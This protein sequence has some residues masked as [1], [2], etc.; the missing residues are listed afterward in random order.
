MKKFLFVLFVLSA[1]VSDAQIWFDIGLKGGAGAGFGLNKTVNDDSR[2]D[3]T[4]GFN[5]FFGGKI[6][7]N[8]GEFVGLTFDVD[9]GGYKFGFNQAEVPL[10]SQTETYKYSLSYNAINFMPMFRFTKERSYLEIGPQFQLLRNQLIEDEAYPALAPTGTSYMNNRL[11]GIT[12]GFG[13]HMI[14]NEIISLMMGFRLN[15]V[16]SDLTADTWDGSNFPLTNYPDITVHSK[17]SPLNVQMVLEINYSL[18]Y[19]ARSTTACGKRAAF[20]TF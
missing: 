13:G 9:Y 18:G 7:V 12:F 17:T 4:P 20:L 19:I 15:Y 5:Y 16:I 10:K 11:T 3:P 14:G 2:F 1:S 6:G 8:Y